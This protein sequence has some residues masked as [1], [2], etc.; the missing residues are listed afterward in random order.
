MIALPW[1][2]CCKFL[3]PLIRWH[4]WIWEPCC[5]YS[6]EEGS[7]FDNHKTDSNHYWFS[8]EW[9]VF[10]EAQQEGHVKLKNRGDFYSFYFISTHTVFQTLTGWQQC[11]HYDHKE[12][13]NMGVGILLCLHKQHN[14][15]YRITGT[16]ILLAAHYEHAWFPS[17]SNN[18]RVIF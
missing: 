6:S 7:K 17:A 1:F 5:P 11:V 18:S 10:C 16:C 14:L 2:L 3:A 9:L 8:F 12:G 4:G 13:G 15:W